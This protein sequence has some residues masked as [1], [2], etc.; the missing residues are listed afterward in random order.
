MKILTVNHFMVPMDKR[1]H[2]LHI[3]W[4]SESETK[5]LLYILETNIVNKDEKIDKDQY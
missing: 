1:N 5:Q 2:A 3:N 4:A